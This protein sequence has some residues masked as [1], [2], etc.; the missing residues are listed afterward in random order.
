MLLNGT[1]THLT[2]FGEKPSCS[3]TPNATPASYPT[4]VVLE[5]GSQ[6]F[7][8]A[9]W[10]HGGNAGLSVAMVSWPGLTSWSWSFAHGLASNDPVPVPAGVVGALSSDPQPAAMTARASTRRER[11]IR[12]RRTGLRS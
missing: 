5:V 6:G 10:N 1:T 7:P 8:F 12:K 3:A 11:G 2:S 9:S 4:G